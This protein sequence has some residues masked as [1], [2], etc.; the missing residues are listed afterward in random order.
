MNGLDNLDYAL[1]AIIVLGALYGLSRG[2]LRILTSILSLLLGTIAATNWFPNLGALIQK[3]SSLSATVADIIGFVVIFIIAVAV[4]GYAGRRI[5][6]LAQAVILSWID[7]L[8]GLIIGLVVGAALAGVAVVVLTAT[9]PPDWRQLRDSR[10]APRVLAFDDKLI[11][12]VPPDAQRLF[13]EKRNA[14]T[15]YWQQQNESPAT[16]STGR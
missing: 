9:M 4:V 15:R 13:E 10:L 12:F 7:R 8:A 5:A 3:H 6:L 11:S 14:L 1:V 16:T 2:V